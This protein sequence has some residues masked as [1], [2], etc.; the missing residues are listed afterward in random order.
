M[1]NLLLLS[2][3]VAFTACTAPIV[4]PP[5]TIHVNVPDKRDYS[6]VDTNHN[7]LL[8]TGREMIPEQ[9]LCQKKYLK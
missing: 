3:L 2:S 9:H 1:K 7:S 5:K 4:K 8:S 6:T